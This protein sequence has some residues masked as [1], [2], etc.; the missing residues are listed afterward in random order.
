MPPWAISSSISKRST[1][2]PFANV[3]S[4]SRPTIEAP[5][6]DLS[7]RAAVSATRTQPTPGS[8]GRRRRGRGGLGQLGPV[9]HEVALGRALRVQAQR[10]R[11][12][13]DVAAHVDRGG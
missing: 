7:A 12:L 2:S 6:R 5:G 10:A 13:G 4:E 1:R 8:A 3:E 9:A 11:V